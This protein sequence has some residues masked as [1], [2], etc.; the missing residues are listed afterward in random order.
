MVL[1]ESLTIPL[2]Y[3]ETATIFPRA[4]GPSENSNGL[5]NTEGQ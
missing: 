4:E 1:L 2:I 3:M 5:Q